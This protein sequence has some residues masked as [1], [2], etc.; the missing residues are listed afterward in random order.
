M[1]D[2]VVSGMSVMTSIGTNIK[3]FWRGLLEEKHGIKEIKSFDVSQHT[4]KLGCEIEE[5]HKYSLN[6]LK[7][8]GRATSILIPP[9]ED[10]LY[11]AGMTPEDLSS[12]RIGLSVG[13]TMGEISSLERSLNKHVKSGVAGPHVITESFSEYY[14]LNG[15]QWTLTNACAAGNFAIARA[16]DEIRMG[17][18]D[19]MI[20]CGV[21][22][23][24]WV[25][26]TGFNSLRAMASDFCRP[27][28][29]DRKGLLL[30]EGAGVLVLE[31]KSHAEKRNIKPRAK[32]C[33]YGLSTDAHHITQP[34][35][36]GEGSI[37]AMKAAIEMSG[38]S[39]EEVGYISAH[40]TGT[41][42]NDK[43]EAYAMS[44]LFNE[45]VLTS[46]IKGNIGHTLGAA[47][48][49]EAALCVK[50]LETGIIPPT[51]NHKNKDPECN[52]HV[53]AGEAKIVNTNYVLSNAFAF[54]G[55]NSSILLGKA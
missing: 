2:I 25:A 28:D 45:K 51:L 21:D 52:V 27:F 48:V 38:I 50:I 15:P 32:L 44:S 39:K 1:D 12:F 55:I 29:A 41:I 4:N 8:Q 24:S 34:D 37:R 43:M 10:A 35:P 30:G 6:P 3:T 49:I 46:S 20:V 33:G 54:G 19:I 22:A 11:D 7:E 16:M 5:A 23:M 18:A 47:S 26:F 42:A 13:T 53:V 9:F 36:K 17:R 31:T 40:G 14:K